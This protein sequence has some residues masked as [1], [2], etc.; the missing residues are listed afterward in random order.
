MA[1]AG[2]VR[3]RARLGVRRLAWRS[4]GTQAAGRATCCPRTRAAASPGG[5]R[6]PPACSRP[7]RR[8]GTTFA[9]PRGRGAHAR[10]AA[11]LRNAGARAPLNFGCPGQTTSGSFRAPIWWR[12]SLAAPAPANCVVWRRAGALIWPAKSRRRGSLQRAPFVFGWPA[13]Q[14]TARVRGPAGADP[15]QASGRPLARARGSCEPAN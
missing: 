1:G 6:A 4:T 13:G 14:L 5:P 11:R 15:R 2:P 8:P 12:I 7:G 9:R 3:V 10:P